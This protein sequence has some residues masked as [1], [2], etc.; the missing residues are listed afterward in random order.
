MLG[1]KLI[2]VSKRVPGTNLGY[3]ASACMPYKD[4]NKLELDIY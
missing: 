4:S 1:L 3:E 2:H